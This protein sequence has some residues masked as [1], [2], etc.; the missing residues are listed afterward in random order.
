MREAWGYFNY[1]LQKRT[2]MFWE[3][4]HAGAWGWFKFNLRSN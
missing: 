4:P 3:I 2:V 1:N